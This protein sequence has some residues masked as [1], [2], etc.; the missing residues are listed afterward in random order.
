MGYI[1]KQRSDGSTAFV[2]NQTDDEVLRMEIDNNVEMGTYASPVQL[3]AASEELFHIN[4]APKGDG[5]GFT[6]CLFSSTEN[7]GTSDNLIGVH[8]TCHVNAN[9]SPKTV[10]A[11]QGHA[12]L[13]DATSSL[14]TR[15]GDTTAGMYGAWFKISSPAS[16]S[17]DAGSYTAAVWLDN[18]H[19]GTVSGTEYTIFSSTGGSVP[20]AWAG[21]STTSSGWTNLLKFEEDDAPVE[22]GGTGDITF[23]GAWK[24][25]AIDIAGTTYYLVV[26]ASPS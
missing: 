11:I 23:S 16:S 3:Q 24:K 14:A 10:Q 18:Q 17:L 26:S 9:G 21:F 25:I 2:N 13:D 19:S 20:T 5:G 6:Y 22:S 7:Q 4:A 1:T 12:I 15:G 8:N